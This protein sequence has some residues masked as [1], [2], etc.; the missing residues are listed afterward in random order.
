ML[1]A[2][3]APNMNDSVDIV[4]VVEIE[5]VKSR[6]KFNRRGG[7]RQQDHATKGNS[8]KKYYSEREWKIFAA[9]R[10]DFRAGGRMDNRR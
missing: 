8:R 1:I 5:K 2:L 3:L 9:L 4:D 7:T 10:R 6:D